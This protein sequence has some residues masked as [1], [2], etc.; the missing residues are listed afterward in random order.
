MTTYKIKRVYE[1]ISNNDGKR[2]LVDRLWPRGVKKEQAQIDYWAKELAPTR[3]LIS[4]FH[5]DKENRYKE[6]ASIYQ[7]YLKNSKIDSD[8][9]ITNN[10]LISLVTA[11]KDIKHSH[12]PSLLKYLNKK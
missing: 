9:V 5:E 2:I 3:E 6:F 12:L 11:V 7:N 4:W 8:K 10:K 1:T